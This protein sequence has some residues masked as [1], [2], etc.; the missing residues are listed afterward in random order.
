MAESSDNIKTQNGFIEHKMDTDRVPQE[1]V[2]IPD[3]NDKETSKSNEKPIS[4]EDIN[5]LP[6]RK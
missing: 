6:E 5:K 3:L 4:N 1:P 2:R